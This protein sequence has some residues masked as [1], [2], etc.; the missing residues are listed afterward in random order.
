MEVAFSCWWFSTP[1]CIRQFGHLVNSQDLV[2]N[3]FLF[4]N[5]HPQKLKSQLHSN[6]GNKLTQH[7]LNSFSFKKKTNKKQ[8]WYMMYD[9]PFE[10]QVPVAFSIFTE[11]CNHTTIKHC[12]HTS[13]DFPGGS[14]AKN[15]RLQWGPPFQ[16]LALGTRSHTLQLKILRATTRTWCRQICIF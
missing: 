16:P 8:L 7:S 13:S 11:V 14:V 5:I 3:Y 2:L 4:K 10:V 9:H 12:P 6:S 15:P 1:N